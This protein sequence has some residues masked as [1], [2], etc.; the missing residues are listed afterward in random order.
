MTGQRRRQDGSCDGCGCRLARDNPGRS[1]ATCQRRRSEARGGPRGRPGVSLGRPDAVRGS[2]RLD[3]STSESTLDSPKWTDLESEP[4][5]EL[6]SALVRE[7]DAG[8]NVAPVR[9]LACQPRLREWRKAHGLTLDAVGELLRQAARDNGLPEPTATFQTMWRHENGRALPTPVYRRLYCLVY[10]AN[11][12]ELGFRPPLPG[13]AFR[14]PLAQ[15]GLTR[16]D[17]S[18]A[19]AP[20]QAATDPVADSH[21]GRRVV[22]P[23]RRSRRSRGTVL[24]VSEADVQVVRELTRTFRGLDNRFGGG[25]AHSLVVQYLDSSVTPMLRDGSYAEEIG[26]KLF[27]SA[28]QLSHLAAWTA[29]DI[30]SH[31]RTRRYLS[32]ALELASAADDRGFGGEVLAAIGH[33]AIHLNQPSKA[34]ELA[35][36]AQQAARQA[37]IPVL[38]SESLALEANSHALLGDVKACLSS[39]RES[40]LAFDRAASAESPEW[41]T[42]FDERYLATRV[43]HSLCE[44][45]DFTEARRYARQALGIGGRLTRTHAFNTVMLANT[46]A[47]DDAEEAMR[48]CRHALSMARN[49]QSDRTVSYIKNLG[50]RLRRHHRGDPILVSFSDELAA[51]GASKWF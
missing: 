12:A 14:S 13:E 31:A 33:Q 25:R 45:G 5:W 28:A 51:F 10:E 42:Y 16:L 2:G 48:L 24:S 50:R 3:A 20:G 11:D 36:A 19:F 47:R 34:L 35:R 9:R 49:L 26:R 30:E 8:S 38:L 6:Q 27:A 41:L 37:A 21:L 4:G 32:K 15:E 17:E 40:E 1:C 7:A 43:A 29:Y 39:L 22:E 18:Q 23:S 46:Y 44:I